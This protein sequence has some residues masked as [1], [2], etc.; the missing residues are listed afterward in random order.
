MC[1]THHHQPGFQGDGADGGVVFHGL[2]AHAKLITT[3]QS[4]PSSVL[5]FWDKITGICAGTMPYRRDFPVTTRI[6]AFQ[7]KTCKSCLSCRAQARAEH[8]WGRKKTGTKTSNGNCIACTD[9]YSCCG[10]AGGGGGLPEADAPAQAAAAT[11]TSLP[12]RS[13]GS[14]AVATR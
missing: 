2:R 12:R 1:A 13:A 6:Q 14:A 9:A 8:P 3:T 5:A 10:S 4:W 11:R 7:D